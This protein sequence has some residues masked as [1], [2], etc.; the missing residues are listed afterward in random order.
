MHRNSD[1]IILLLCIDDMLITG[2]SSTLM[3][4]FLAELKDEFAMKNLDDV[5]YFLGIQ[6]TKTHEGL[7]LS[8]SR[9]AG[10]ILKKAHLL[11]CKPLS[12]PMIRR[13]RSP[14]YSPLFADPTH[15]RAIFGSLQ[16][17]TFTRLDIAFAV[18]RVPEHAF[19]NKGI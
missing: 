15:Y 13:Y 19:S 11:N 16:Y 1:S 2:N 5:H 7:F 6:I 4:L 9:Y 18:N 12:T 3:D 8:Q 17:L 10:Q 14:D